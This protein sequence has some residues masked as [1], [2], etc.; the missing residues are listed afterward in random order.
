V[1]AEDA[2]T[3]GSRARVIRR[4]SGMSLRVVAE[5]AGI[6]KGYLS[7][8]ELGQ[9]GFNRRG[10]IDDLATALGCSV[11][12]L[13]GQPYGVELQR[14]AAPPCTSTSPGVGAGRGMSKRSATWTP[15]TGSLPPGPATTHS[16]GSWC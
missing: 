8:L 11:A 7:M 1:D 13:T 12:D 15:P 2:R 9:R 16:L 6:T 3:I 4:R 14:T 5:L 10:L